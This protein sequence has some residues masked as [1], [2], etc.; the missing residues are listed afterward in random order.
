MSAI[1]GLHLKVS[2]MLT[3]SFRVC[4][5]TEMRKPRSSV[6]ACEPVHL[7][8]FPPK[9]PFWQALNYL[10]SSLPKLLKY[11]R[12]WSNRNSFFL[13]HTASRVS[14]MGWRRSDMKTEKEQRLPGGVK[15]AQTTAAHHNLFH[16]RHETSAKRKNLSNVNNPDSFTNGVKTYIWGKKPPLHLIFILKLKF[17]KSQII[18]Q[19][20]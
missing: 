17:Q 12:S 1:L 11:V 19:V 9:H 3:G 20:I 14:S 10:H 4:I 15:D 16:E 7:L 6:T 13:E 5:C 18:H 2:S 8:I